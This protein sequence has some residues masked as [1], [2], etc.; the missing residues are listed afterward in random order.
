METQTNDPA[1]ATEETPSAT[2]PS[3]NEWLPEAYRANEGF[4]AFKNI[5]DLAKSYDG[6]RK[7]VG[8][9]PQFLVRLPRDG[10]AEETAA[11]Y[12]RLGRPE[13]PD[14]YEFNGIE[15]K[16]EGDKAFVEGFRQHAFDRGLTQAQ[17]D[18]VLGYLGGSMAQLDAAYEKQAGEYRAATEAELRTQ[19][20]GKYDVYRAE[21]PATV[22]KLAAKAGYSGDEAKAIYEKLNADGVTDNPAFMRLMA[23]VAD[24]TAESGALPGGGGENTQTANLSVDQASQALD[25]FYLDKEKAAAVHDT[26]HPGHKA[27]K[28]EWQRLVAAKAG[29]TG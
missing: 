20:G 13:A 5:D 1:P 4:T 23:V 22:E 14:K 26:R 6:A 28:D 3:T 10:N 7:L 11:L 21:V 24:M 25:A 16:N 29:A 19:W 9:D 8:V 27:A 17:M 12:N 15:L 2:P 18:G